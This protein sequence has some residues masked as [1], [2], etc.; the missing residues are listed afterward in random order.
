LNSASP[1]VKLFS[2]AGGFV[3]DKKVCGDEDAVD[4]ALECRRG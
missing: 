3:R 2:G 1:R 4:H